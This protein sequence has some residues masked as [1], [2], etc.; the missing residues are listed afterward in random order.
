MLRSGG[1]AFSLRQGCLRVDPSLG[2][3]GASPEA[4]LSHFPWLRLPCRAWG[5]EVGSG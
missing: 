2:S 1:M 5:W 4:L 3:E